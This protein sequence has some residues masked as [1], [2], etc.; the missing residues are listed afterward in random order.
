M[1]PFLKSLNII[2]KISVTNYLSW[3]NNRNQMFNTWTGCN[4]NVYIHEQSEIEDSCN[5]KSLRGILTS[6]LRTKL[7]SH[8]IFLFVIGIRLKL[9]ENLNMHGTFSMF[10][11][12]TSKSCGKLYPENVPFHYILYLKSDPEVSLDAFLYQNKSPLPI[13]VISKDQILFKVGCI[14]YNRE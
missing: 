6:R 7:S 11:N 14:L 2:Q 5:H 3:T 4:E 1:Q 13:T 8:H 9:F 10:Q 12:Y